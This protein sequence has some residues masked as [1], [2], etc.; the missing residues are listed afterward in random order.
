GRWAVVKAQWG[1]GGKTFLDWK[2]WSDSTAA[3][4][5]EECSRT[6]PF[7]CL[8]L[9]RF[10]MSAHSRP[11]RKGGHEGQIAAATSVGSETSDGI[12]TVD[13]DELVDA[14]QALRV[15]DFSV[16]LRTDRQGIAA[17][18]ADAFNNVAS[19]NQRMAQQLEHVAELEQR[20][21]ERTLELA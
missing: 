8:A 13:A 18:I 4:S 20:A 6:A 9:G 7:F 19:A 15:G 14:L 2:T 10:R 5:K 11:R 21:A 17:R 16:R 3:V 1:V 12:A